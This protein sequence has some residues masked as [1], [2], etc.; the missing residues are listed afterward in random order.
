MTQHLTKAISDSI[1]N[2]WNT[3]IL[4]DF[5]GMSL[6]GADVAER[7]G[8][9]HVILKESGIKQGDKIALCARNSSTWATAFLGA[10]TYGAVVVPLLHEFHP[11]NVEHLVSHSEARILFTEKSIFDQLDETRLGDLL[12][13]VLI[14]EMKIAFSRNKHLTKSVEQIDNLT[15]CLL[16][17]WLS[18]IIHPAPPATPRV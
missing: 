1:K 6:T 16:T 9:I 3:P 12:G 7:I 4:S 18:L 11:E 17:V 2:N 5:Q 15:P 14:P 10:L 8:K 13:A